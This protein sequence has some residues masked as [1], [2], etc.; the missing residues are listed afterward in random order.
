[1]TFLRSPCVKAPRVSSLFATIEAKRRSPPRFVKSSLT[2]RRKQRTHQLQQL[3]SDE[4]VS[5]TFAIVQVQNQL[6][7]RCHANLYSGA[8]V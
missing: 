6:H 4:K 8:D 5:I 7:K 1:M 3:I 2:G